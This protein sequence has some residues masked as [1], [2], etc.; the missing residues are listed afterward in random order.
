MLLAVVLKDSSF[1]KRL[2]CWC[3]Y[4]YI[5]Q[6][7]LGVLSGVQHRPAAFAAY[8]LARQF[9]IHALCLCDV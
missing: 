9:G 7:T 1:K 4:I 3:L 8:A 6:V 2:G 5:S